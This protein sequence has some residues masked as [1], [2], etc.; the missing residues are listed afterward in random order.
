MSNR[1]EPPFTC[2]ADAESW[3]TAA[4]IGATKLGALGLGVAG[5]QVPVARR[6]HVVLELDNVEQA[7]HWNKNIRN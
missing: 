5:P 7:E 6:A 3:G 1:R 4:A 2:A